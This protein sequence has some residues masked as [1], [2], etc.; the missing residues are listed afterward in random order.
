MSEFSI[1]CGRQLLVTRNTT[2]NPI[3][4][5]CACRTMSEESPLTKSVNDDADEEASH[6]ES[7]KQDEES[8]EEEQSATKSVPNTP[9]PPSRQQMTPQQMN[10]PIQQY[11]PPYP[12]PHQYP[13]MPLPYPTQATNI[14]G[15]YVDMSQQMDP[16]ADRR[17]R[18]GVTEPFPEKLYRMLEVC[19][20]DGHG[21]IVSFFSHG[22]AFAIHKPRKFEAE[23]MPK[24]FRQSK[25]TSF[26]R[27]LNLCTYLMCYL[28]VSFSCSIS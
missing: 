5:S 23:V 14:S 6:E 19:E 28:V 13:I 2:A 17:N 8:E 10:M 18:G 27:Q 25:M 1:F 9:V 11:Y 15:V 20:R 12:Y 16:P 3:A 26:Q 21:D 22:R 7:E 4:Y 24:F